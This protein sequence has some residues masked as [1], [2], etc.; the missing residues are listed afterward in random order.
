MDGKELVK[1]WC[2][3]RYPMMATDDDYGE[4]DCYDMFEFAEWLFLKLNKAHVIGS[5]PEHKCKYC[6]VMTT[7]PDEECYKA[8]TGN[9][10]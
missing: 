1:E 6:G 9:D 3:G 7:Q 5:L 2:K 4:L 10:L 8:P